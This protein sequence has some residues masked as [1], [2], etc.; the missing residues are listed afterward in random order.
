[1][2]DKVDKVDALVKL[3]SKA[4]SIRHANAIN[5]QRYFDSFRFA[6]IDKFV[7]SKLL[8]SLTQT[9]MVYT[10]LEFLAHLI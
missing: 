3:T 5:E 1:M 9:T 8:Y 4:W 6:K 10:V 7:Y 2:V